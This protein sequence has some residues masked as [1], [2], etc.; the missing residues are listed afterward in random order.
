MAISRI[1]ITDKAHIL[2]QLDSINVN[3]TTVY[4]SIDQTTVHL[5][6]RYRG[7]RCA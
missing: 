1:T 5:R 2:R 6:E 7:G 3:A 4:P